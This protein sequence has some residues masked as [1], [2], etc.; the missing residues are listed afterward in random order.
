[1]AGL[2]AEETKLIGELKELGQGH[3]FESWTESKPQTGDVKRLASQLT[4]LNKQYQGGLSAYIKNARALLKASKEGANAF[5]G[6]V[7]KKPSGIPLNFDSK[8]FHEMEEAGMKVIGQTAYC[9]VAGGL[10]ERLG[11]NG[12]KVELPYECVTETCYLGLYCR[13]ILA[14]QERA[15]KAGMKDC[16]LPLA[17]MTSGDTDEKTKVLLKKNNN[18]GMA[19]GQIVIVKQEKVPSLGDNKGSFVLKKDD[20]Y[21]IQTKPHGHGDVHL[22]LHESG[23]ARKWAK[24]GRKY[25]MFFQDTNGLVFNAAPAAFGVSASMGFEVNSLTVP[26]RP[27]EAVGAICQL[28]SKERTFT[29]NVE[30]NQLAGLMKDAGYGGDV[31]DSTGFSPYPGNLNILIFSIPEYADTLD[32]C[33]GQVPEFVNP[34]YKDAAKTIFKKPTRLECMMQDYPKLLPTGAKVGFV[35][36]ERAVCFSAVKNNAVDA[37]GKQAKTGFPESACSGEA[38]AYKINRM[39]VAT[40]KDAKI[41]VDGNEIEFNRI[42]TKVGAKLVFQPSFACTMSEFKKKFPK[43]ENISIGNEATIVLDGEGITV[44]KLQMN[45]GYLSV[46][47]CPGAEVVIDYKGDSSPLKMK[48]EG[49]FDEGSSSFSYPEGLEEKYCIRGYTMVYAGSAAEKK[50][51]TFVFDKPGK[52]VVKA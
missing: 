43:P 34:K 4:T 52:F 28:E 14:L 30:Y 49:K 5:T 47:A 45:S 17:I 33:K 24:E 23:L 46:T 35:S 27:G 7:P 13:H 10:G 12:I 11:Y 32:K 51:Q 20:K 36:L 8:K 9:I 38:D 29:C 3:L 19:E 6:Y 1:M 41:S 40:L 39:K 15:K 31:A 50:K 44:E 16:V 48:A 42:K 21:S 2:S 37:R 18:F 25:L 22:L 26:R